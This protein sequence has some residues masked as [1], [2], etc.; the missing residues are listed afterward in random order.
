M[1]GADMAERF[2]V[3]TGGEPMLQVDAA[4]CDALHARGFMIAMESNGT[5]AAAP[6]EQELPDD[7]GT[8]KDAVL[9]E[10]EQFARFAIDAE[11]P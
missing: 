11:E 4:L 3:L 5:I 2:V 7:V 6:E 1:W 10:V 8:A 9:H